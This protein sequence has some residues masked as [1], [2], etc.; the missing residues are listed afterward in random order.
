MGLRFEQANEANVR[1]LFFP[2]GKGFHESNSIIYV[3][4]VRGNV[5]DVAAQL[6]NL[7]GLSDR[8]EHWC[9]LAISL[10]CCH[11]VNVT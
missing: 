6:R 4:E 7:T 11:K 3:N 1:L 5:S 9:Y 10:A 8:G 2:E